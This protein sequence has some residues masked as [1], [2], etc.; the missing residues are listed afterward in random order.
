MPTFPLFFLSILLTLPALSSFCHLLQPFLD[1]SITKG[2]FANLSI[3]QII[4]AATLLSIVGSIC[5]MQATHI[6]RHG[7]LSYYAGGYLIVLL[8][9]LTIT[10]LTTYANGLSFHLHHYQLSLLLLPL[11]R[12]QTKF[13]VFCTGLL[14]GMFVNGVACYGFDS[15]WVL[16]EPPPAPHS[17][18]PH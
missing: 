16:F 13:C 6:Y 5:L 4:F 1:Y 18:T 8:V 3:P 15:T 14:L 7:L 12:F 10:L 11:V 2:G 17:V 9:C